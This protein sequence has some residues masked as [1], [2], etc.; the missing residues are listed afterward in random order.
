MGI[1]PLITATRD[2]YA[3]KK[4]EKE[5][6]KQYRFMYRVFRNA[7]LMLNRTDTDEDADRYS[8]PLVKSASM[9]MRSRF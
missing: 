1:L 5:L 2:A 6:I 3:H 4:S 7:R 8:K 9:N